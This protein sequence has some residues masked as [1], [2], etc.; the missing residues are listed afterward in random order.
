M[1]EGTGIVMQNRGSHFSL[2]DAHANRL[3]PGKRTLHTLMPGLVMRD[4]RPR[5]V[6]GTRGAGGQP[7][8]ICNVL[9]HWLDGDMSLQEAIEA[10]RWLHGARVL[11]EDP[12]RLRIEPRC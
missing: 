4:G 6:V 7:Q 9:I 2:D 8:T 12:D 1:S 5:A 3:E 11:G 10:P